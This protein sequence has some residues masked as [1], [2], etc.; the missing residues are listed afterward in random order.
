MTIRY[1]RAERL[2]KGK[3]MGSQKNLAMRTV[4]KCQDTDEC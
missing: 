1:G 2:V 4:G 3:M